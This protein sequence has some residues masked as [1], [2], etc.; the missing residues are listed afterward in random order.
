MEDFFFAVQQLERFP[1]MVSL[2]FAAIAYGFIREVAQSG[3]LALISVPVVIAGSLTSHYLLNANSIMLANDKD[4]NVVSGIAIGMLAS[5]A[6]LMIGYWLIMVI[7][8]RRSAARKLK[9]LTGSMR[10]AK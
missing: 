2:M 5:F 10:A 3:G 9:P 1:V 6:L 7:A 8:E 4:T